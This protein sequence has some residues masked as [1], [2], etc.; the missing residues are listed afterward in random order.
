MFGFGF[1]RGAFT[2]RVVMGLILNQGL[3]E[4]DNEAELDS[5]ASAAYRAYR[6]ERYHTFWHFEVPFRGC[7]TC[8]VPQYHDK[9]TIRR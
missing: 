4:A 9:A 7:A 1:S 2:I 3:V 5:Q 8:S 6:R